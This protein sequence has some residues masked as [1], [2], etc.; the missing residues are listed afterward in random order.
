MKS[1][2]SQPN[3]NKVVIDGVGDVNASFVYRFLKTGYQREGG[4]APVLP[5][6]MKKR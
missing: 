1:I 2:E 3:S 6:I 5:T 4:S